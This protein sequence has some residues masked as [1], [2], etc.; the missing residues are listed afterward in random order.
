MA[1]LFACRRAQCAVEKNTKSQRM[2]VLWEL[3]SNQPNSTTRSAACRAGPPSNPSPSGLL[4]NQARAEPDRTM[5]D[6]M[7]ELEELDPLCRG[8][9]GTAGGGK[10]IRPE[11]FIRCRAQAPLLS[12]PGERLNGCD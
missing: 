10:L 5:Y 12:Q 8:G 4:L 3:F 11:D 9:L 1:R 7:L 6:K 2:P